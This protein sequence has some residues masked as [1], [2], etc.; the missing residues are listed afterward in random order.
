MIAILCALLQVQQNMM[1]LLP[2][3]SLHTYAR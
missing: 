1:A 3:N 2:A